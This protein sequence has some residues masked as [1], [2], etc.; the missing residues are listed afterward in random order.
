M[1]QS[2][3]KY[4]SYIKDNKT[5]LLVHWLLRFGS[6]YC[7]WHLDRVNVCLNIIVIG[8]HVDYVINDLIHLGKKKQ[9]KTGEQC[10]LCDYEPLTF[11]QG[12]HLFLS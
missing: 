11:R 9:K 3:A 4:I 1:S 6:T 2:D 8:L 10:Y 12:L 5:N 7:V